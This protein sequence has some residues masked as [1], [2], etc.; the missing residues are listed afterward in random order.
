VLV[1]QG[2]QVR[3]LSRALTKTY[4][5]LAAWVFFV[6]YHVFTTFAPHHADS[7]TDAASSSFW[8]R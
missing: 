7:I 1:P 2:L 8:F 4:V 6:F 3:V 5:V